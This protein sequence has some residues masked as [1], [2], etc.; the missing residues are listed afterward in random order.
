ML[1]A[2]VNGGREPK[3]VVEATSTHVIVRMVEAGL[4]VAI[5]PLL[6]SGVVTK[7]LEIGHVPIRGDIRPIDTCIVSRPGCLHD[8]ASQTLQEFLRRRFP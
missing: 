5:V 4:G 1:E 7:N 2:C 8:G 6:P 3:S